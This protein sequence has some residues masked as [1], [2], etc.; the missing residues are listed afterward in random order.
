[1]HLVGVELLHAEAIL[2]DLV[3]SRESEDCGDGSEMGAIQD[4]L[5]V[6]NRVLIV[7]ETL[8][9]LRMALACWSS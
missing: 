3:V 5:G 9:N 2:L 1:M 4:R 8:Q 7:V 6:R